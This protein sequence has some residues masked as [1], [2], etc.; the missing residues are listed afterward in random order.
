MWSLVWINDTNLVG[1]NAV[2]HDPIPAG[3]TF[4]D[5]SVYSGYPLPGGP[6]PPG[7]TSTGV[8]CTAGTSTLT[9]TTLCYYEGPT[10]ANP[11]GQI[12]WAGTLGPDLGVTDPA[13]AAN[14]IHIVFSVTAAGG[15]TSVGNIAT[16]DSDLNGNGTTTDAGEQNVARASASWSSTPTVL[17]STGFAPG[18]VTALPSRT[19]SYASLGDLWLEIPRLGVK[20]PIVGIPASADGSWDVSWLG[21]DAGWLNGT[22]YPTGSGNSV[23]TGHVWNADN[24]PGPFRY[25]NTLWYGDQVI[26]HASGAQYVYAIREMLQV[27]PGSVS[28]MLKH[29][30]LPWITLVTC[31]GYD[32]TDNSYQYRVL[33]RAVLVSVK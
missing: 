7:T 21:G 5:D 27:G 15:V 29:E 3:T 22:A 23:L 33:V 28:T 11:R 24:T 10:V 13:L 17:P 1:V 14:A 32:A 19:V 4:K 16:I 8:S 2:A 25:I 30:D 18:S 6:L 26:I 9:T 12:V 31:R 20:M